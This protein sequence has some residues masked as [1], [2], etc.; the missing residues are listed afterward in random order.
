MRVSACLQV[1]FNYRE[2]LT[3][4]MSGWRER[5]RGE[6]LNIIRPIPPGLLRHDPYL[7]LF[8]QREDGTTYLVCKFCR[9]RHIEFNGRH[10]IQDPVTNWYDFDD[11]CCY[12]RVFDARGFRV[13]DGTLFFARDRQAPGQLRLRTCDYATRSW[14]RDLDETLHHPS[15]CLAQAAF[16]PLR[17]LIL[18]RRRQYHA[19]KAH[20][21]ARFVSV[22]DWLCVPRLNKIAMRASLSAGPIPWLKVH[23]SSPGMGKVGEGRLKV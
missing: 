14:I 1:L 11:E 7:W 21:L 3:D 19:Q 8:I 13:Q 15:A 16:R 20:P 9:W 5:E 23:H 17:A 22:I 2:H 4:S 12:C 6:W 18:C 10:Y